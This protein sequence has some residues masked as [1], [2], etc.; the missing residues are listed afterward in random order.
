M[1]CRSKPPVASFAITYHTA[2][3][4][5]SVLLQHTTHLNRLLVTIQTIGFK[6]RKAHKASAATNSNTT[7]AKYALNSIALANAPCTTENTCT[8]K[9]A[10][11]VVAS[12]IPA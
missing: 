12:C 1:Q 4:C 11:S 5:F 8:D 10:G 9:S 7:T 6:E 2:P 3:Q